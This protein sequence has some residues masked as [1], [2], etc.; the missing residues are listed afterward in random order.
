MAGAFLLFV[1]YRFGGVVLGR[2][3]VAGFLRFGFGVRFEGFFVRFS[4]GF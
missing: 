2:Y 4:F 1:G 3:L